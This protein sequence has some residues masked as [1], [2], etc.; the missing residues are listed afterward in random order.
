MSEE[1]LF[2]L[3]AA[4]GGT[5]DDRK[6]NQPAYSAASYCAQYGIPLEDIEERFGHM[7]S[8]EDRPLHGAVISWLRARYL[9]DRKFTKAAIALETRPFG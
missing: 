8:I 5:T 9:H 7:T 3:P 4:R 2:D 1:H 6:D